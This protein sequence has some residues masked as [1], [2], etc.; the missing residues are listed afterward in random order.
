MPAAQR[1]Q[2]RLEFD[3]PAAFENP[4]VKQLSE[5]FL[6]AV[7]Q[8]PLFA[9]RPHKQQRW[10]HKLKAKLKAFI[11]GN[12]SGKTSTGAVDDI[13]QAIDREWVP[14]HLL[15][16]KIWEPPFKCRIVLPD[17]KQPLQA[18][19]EVLR[20]WV[21]VAQLKG[22]SWETAYSK[23]EEI[24]R[25]E[26]GS[27]FEFLTHE[28]DVEKFGGSA[29][30]RVHYDEELRGEKGEVIRD[31]CSM[32]LIDYGG[33]EIFT[34]TPQHGL[35]PTYDEF[36]EEKGPEVAD[37]VWA[38]DELAVVRASSRDNPHIDQDEVAKRMAKLP[39]AVRRA[40]EEG[41]FMHFKGLVYPMFDREIHIV[42][43]PSPQFVKALQEQRDG[44][45]PGMQ[46][47]AI[48]FGAFDADNILLIY[49]ELYLSD[50]WAIPENAAQK[51]FDK[52]RSWG[53][54]LRPRYT[55]ID[56]SAR[57]RSLTDADSVESAYYRA[58][59]KTSP[60]NNDVEAGVFEVMRRLEH[61]D[62][63]GEPRPLLLISSA[64][65]E[66]LREIARYRLQP[67]DDGSFGVVK[68]DDHGVDTLRYICQ[69]RPIAPRPRRK[70]PRRRRRVPPGTAPPFEPRRP[71]DRGPLGKFS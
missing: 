49:D 27:F 70:P 64:C 47:T 68:K 40:R 55:L 71:S 11:G 44:I 29:R 52:R 24:I 16:Y 1:P 31:E 2:P 12:R 60:A 38:T 69:S 28:Q 5:E 34:F 26:N 22:G 57:N 8:N 19:L 62:A 42:E 36:E 59:V 63:E 67:K 25:F 61:R 46:T 7:E 13:I 17:F 32:R 18:F 54:K 30:H 23:K 9:Y 20:Q 39:E 33:D 14:E 50:R 3:D 4:E 43:P 10:F 65:T 21:P 48:L 53:L 45:D 56:P 15:E 41:E 35:G 6:A 66:L 37:R 58:G 51:I